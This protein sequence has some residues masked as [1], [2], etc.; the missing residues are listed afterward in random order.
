MNISR[1]SIPGTEWTSRNET[2]GGPSYG[3]LGVQRSGVSLDVSATA[4]QVI[5]EPVVVKQPLAE[6]EPMKEEEP[7][8]L[9]RTHSANRA[10]SLQALS[11]VVPA[12]FRRRTPEK[13]PLP[14]PL[15]SVA[16]SRLS[17]ERR[18]VREERNEIPIHCNQRT[19][20]STNLT[21]RTANSVRVVCFIFPT[22]TAMDSARVVW[23]R[24]SSN[25]K[26]GA[27]VIAHITNNSPYYSRNSY[28][29]S[30]RGP[31]ATIRQRLNF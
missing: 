26:A 18:R 24:D 27:L 1:A 8:R 3:L 17:I 2:H 21:Q 9:H 16:L 6:R 4:E 31:E 5:L 14:G 13:R 22:K 29:V 20:Y 11:R 10:N 15:L 12:R 19:P 28:F 25:R 23:L 7:R 30:R